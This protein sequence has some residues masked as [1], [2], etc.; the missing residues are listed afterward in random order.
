MLLNCK[1]KLVL[2]NRPVVMGIINITPDSFYKGYLS[3]SM[4]AILK[5]VEG[6]IKAGAG[7]IDIGGQSTRPG[8][9]GISAEEEM[10]RVLPVIQQIHNKFPEALISIDTY[11]SVVASNAVESG[12]SMVNDISAGLLD[13]E[14][15]STVAR[16]KVP[17]ICMHMKGIPATMQ[18]NT[19]YDD[20]ITEMFDFFNHRI[21]ECIKKGITDIIIDPGFGFGKSVAD[22]F[23][24]LKQL[25]LFRICSKPILIGISRKGTV[26]KTLNIKVE[27]AL[28]GSTVLHTIALLNGAS[29]IRVHDVKEAR[30]VVELMGIYKATS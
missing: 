22:N 29:I 20:I 23:Y 2:F 17:Y 15:L 4:N 11:Y 14:M 19:H 5:E 27:D 30:E 18:L 21:T 16:L 13:N 8:S 7:I 25:P 12:A 6:M 1:G 24:L 3:S 28:N 9:T 26:Y 10:S